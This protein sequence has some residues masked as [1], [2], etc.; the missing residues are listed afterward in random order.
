MELYPGGPL[1]LL[2]LVPPGH[3]AP[4]SLDLEPGME[5]GLEPEYVQYDQGEDTSTLV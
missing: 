3:S 5:A 2:E 4:V 1:S